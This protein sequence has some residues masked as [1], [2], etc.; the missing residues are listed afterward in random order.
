MLSS[1]AVFYPD[2]DIRQP[3]NCELATKSLE[4][5]AKRMRVPDEIC[6]GFS[7]CDFLL[8]TAAVVPI[9]SFIVSGSIVVVNNTVHWVEKQGRCDD[10]ATQRAI[11]EFASWFE[12]QPDAVKI[13]IPED[14]PGQAR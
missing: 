7:H 4:L 1:C 2:R 6:A 3:R 12:T 10:S 11:S 9:G 14:V 8:V 5:E 13:E